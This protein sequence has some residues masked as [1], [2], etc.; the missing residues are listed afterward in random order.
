MGFYTEWFADDSDAGAIA[1]IVTT[2]ERS[3]TDWPN[4]SMKNIGEMDLSCLWG[5]LRGEPDSDPTV[6]G[7]LLFQE[8]DEIF[9]CR[10]KRSFIEALTTIEPASLDAIV[11]AWN[12]SENLSRWRADELEEVVRQ[13]V[14]FAGRARDARKPVL[15]L[16]V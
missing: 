16:S 4:L 3:P 9:V 10:V 6:T 12:K 2:E 7:D 8:G 15:L 11:E 1:S 5:I 14:D 13:L